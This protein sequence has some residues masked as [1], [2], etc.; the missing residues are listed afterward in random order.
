MT[1]IYP[2]DFACPK[3]EKPPAGDA[4]LL[5]QYSVRALRL[6]YFLCGD[7]RICDY[8]KSLLRQTISRWRNESAVASD[9]PYKKLYKEFRKTLEETLRYYIRTAGYRP[10]KFKRKKIRV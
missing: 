1:D 5:R 4:V 7:C 3:C 2:D 10:G 8:S 6:P 9:V